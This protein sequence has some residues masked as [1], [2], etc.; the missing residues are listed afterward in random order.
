MRRVRGNAATMTMTKPALL[1]ALL[2]VA[3]PAQAS[4]LD[5][6]AADGRLS[7]LVTAIGKSNA[8]AVLGGKGPFT[9]FA[10]TNEAFARLD[11][12]VL[13]DLLR[14]A[15]QPRLD[16]L[17]SYHVV[18]GRVAAAEVAGRRSLATANGQL[19]P[20]RGS[21]D[22]L[23]IDEAGLVITDIVCSNGI[24]H[25]VDAVLLPES[26]SLAAIA[27]GRSQFRTL[28]A[29]IEAA[30]LT[31][32]LSGE[33][34]FTVLAPTNAAFEKLP[35]GTV[36]AL[37]QPENRERLQAILKFHVIPGRISASAAVAAG[38][39]KTLEGS[40]VA[41]EVV[42]GALRVQGAVVVKNDIQ[43]ANGTVHVIDSV[44]LPPEPAQPKGRLV[45]GVSVEEPSRALAAQLELAEGEGLVVTDLTAGSGAQKAGLKP[46]DVVVAID[47][48]PASREVLAAAKQR[49]GAGGVLQFEVARAGKRKA[50][51][52]EV[53][54]AK[55]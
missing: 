54:L 52:I 24:V 53:G 31:K 37:L 49:V 39:A 13:Q 6:A 55:H 20:I 19:L 7:T 21:G 28:V 30:G 10:P 17:L 27:K 25:V 29:A 9:V 40:S 11:P 35:A 18:P 22:Q 33:G 32:A 4:I 51:P 46:L 15:Q 34:P 41:F 3:V 12:E 42:D 16:A 8:G 38:N 45:V 23:R 26:R 5:T 50:L 14:P 2:A 47:G 48:K 1:V 36:E 43:A 44:L